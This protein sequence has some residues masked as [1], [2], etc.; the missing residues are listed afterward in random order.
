MHISLY[1]LHA[2]I[3][4]YIAICLAS[5]TYQISEILRI[6]VFIIMI[7]H[8]SSVT[9]AYINAMPLRDVLTGH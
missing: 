6:L 8:G 1:A 2:Y 3:H 5:Q 7:C 9:D 4:A